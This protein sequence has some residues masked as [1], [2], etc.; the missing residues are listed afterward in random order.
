MEP[1]KVRIDELTLLFIAVN[2]LVDLTHLDPNA[3]LAI[4]N[5]GSLFA[6]HLVGLKMKPFK[7]TNKKKETVRSF[8]TPIFMHLGI[9]LDEGTTSTSRAY[10]YAAHLLAAMWLT[11]GQRWRFRM[12][13]HPCLLQLPARHTTDFDGC[14]D[15]LQFL[16]EER[17]LR[18]LQ[19]IPHRVHECAEHMPLRVHQRHHFLTSPSYQSSPS[20]IR[21]TFRGLS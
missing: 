15:R 1:N 3:E 2:G 4:P 16:P 17:L 11:E 18:N 13:E 19:D 14:V 5:L 9:R 20:M 10:L 6:Q 21:E 12:G 7:G 8:L